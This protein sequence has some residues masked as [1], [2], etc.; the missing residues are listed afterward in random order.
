MFTQDGA[1]DLLQIERSSQMND[2]KSL[3]AVSLHLPA[4]VVD[5]KWLLKC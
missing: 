1:F 4:V 2:L 5:E 3:T